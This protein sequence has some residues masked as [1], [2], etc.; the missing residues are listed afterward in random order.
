MMPDLNSSI[1]E[2]TGLCYKT[3][4]TIYWL[5]KIA[6]VRWCAYFILFGWIMPWSEFP[7]IHEIE[8]D[9]FD[10]KIWRVEALCSKPQITHHVSFS[11]HE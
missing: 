10:D 5:V 7:I 2:L 6:A 8:Q 9:L 11:W 4:F 3:I 1:R